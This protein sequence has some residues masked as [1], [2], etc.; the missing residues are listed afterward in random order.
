MDRSPATHTTRFH[1]SFLELDCWR[2]GCDRCSEG[3][4][5]I[6]VGKRT[7]GLVWS[8]AGSRSGRRRDATQR[9]SRTEGVGGVWLPRRSISPSFVGSKRTNQ[10]RGPRDRDR[11]IGNNGNG[12]GHFNSPIDRVYTLPYL[13]CTTTGIDMWSVG[14]DHHHHILLVVHATPCLV[15]K[16]IIHRP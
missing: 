3:I 15:H 5:G 14:L 6:P 7:P 13:V 12:N 10:R 1:S 9:C 16:Y 2:V 4:S 11:D 8:V